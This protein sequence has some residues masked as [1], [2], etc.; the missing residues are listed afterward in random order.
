M[1]AEDSFVDVMARLDREDP[2]AADE[3]VRRYGQQLIA[4]VAPRLLGAIG[5]KV[6]AEDLVQ[7]ALGS[8][9]RSN[10]Q[11]P[12]QLQGWDNLWGLLAT[13]TLRKC[14]FQ[15]RQYLTQ[16]RHVCRETSLD[17]N[18]TDQDGLEAICGSPTPL[19]AA[20][21][22][23]LVEQLLAGLEGTTRIIAELILQGQSAPEIAP[24]IGL[25]ERSVY[26]QLERIRSRLRA[27]DEP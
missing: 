10:S 22:G 24:K 6:D 16:K 18:K 13:M 11:E 19:E 20:A 25:T 2:R 5:R 1:A 12:F 27:L 14:R 3:I 26:R 7:S 21:L 9:F 4:F 8:F 23:D 17:P 15:V